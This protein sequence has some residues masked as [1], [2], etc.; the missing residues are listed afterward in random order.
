[1]SKTKIEWTQR[2]WNISKGCSKISDGC[3]NCYA[4]RWA[5]RLQAMGLKDY[6]DGFKFKILPHRLE[7]PLHIK[8]PS[9]I[10]VNSM[11][12]LF[13]REMPFEYIDKVLQIIEATPQHTYQILTKRAERMHNYFEYKEVPKNVWLGISIESGKYKYRIDYFWYLKAR[14]KFISF[15]PLIAPVGELDLRGIDWIIV[16]AETGKEARPMNKKWV[17]E[18]FEQTKMTGLP[19][20]FKRWGNGSRIYKGREWNEFPL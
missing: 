14:V 3:K 13:H 10:F 6:Q 12:D 16:G 17:D 20:F 4:E 1:M 7:E 15:E 11:S 8:K 18:I 5:K 9:L 19:F 2:V